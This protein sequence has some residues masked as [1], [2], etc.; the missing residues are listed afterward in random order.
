MQLD[1]VALR[2]FALPHRLLAAGDPVAR[3]SF[4]DE[5]AARFM[6]ATLRWSAF[7]FVPVADEHP[8]APDGT[9]DANVPVTADLIDLI[10]AAT[11]DDLAV[12]K[13]L[14]PKKAAE[15]IENAQAFVAERAQAAANT[16]PLNAG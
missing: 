10:A 3:M 14:G 16:Q 15:I 6:Q 9:P 12:I 5:G 4:P 1:L 7:R 8:T 2:P 11:P 13:G